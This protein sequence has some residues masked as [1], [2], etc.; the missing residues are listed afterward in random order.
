MLLVCT[1]FYRN[2]II[3]G[4]AQLKKDPPCS[5]GNK[6]AILVSWLIKHHIKRLHNGSSNREQFFLE[7]WL[8]CKCMNY[9]KM[10]HTFDPW[11]VVALCEMPFGAVLCSIQGYVANN[12]K[13]LIINKKFALPLACVRNGTSSYCTKTACYSRL[14]PASDNSTA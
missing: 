1:F 2:S 10:K 12:F 13:H 11:A 3:L 7:I 4:V 6:Q 5:S 8:C 14:D 9:E